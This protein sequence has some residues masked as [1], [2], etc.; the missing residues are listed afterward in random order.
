[1]CTL[2]LR[3]GRRKHLKEE[4][5]EEEEEEGHLLDDEGCCHSLKDQDDGKLEEI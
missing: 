5:E 4:E 1:M 3:D 2:P